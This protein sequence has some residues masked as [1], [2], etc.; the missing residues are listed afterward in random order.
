VDKYFYTCWSCD[1]T[2]KVIYTLNSLRK[3]K[4]LF[5]YDDGNK[6]INKDDI[7]NIVKNAVFILIF[8]DDK[9]LDYENIFNCLES[10]N[11]YNKDLIVVTLEGNINI[12][13]NYKYLLNYEDCF[14][15]Y[16]EFTKID[17]FKIVKYAEVLTF[18][19]YLAGKTNE[20]EKIYKNDFYEIDDN[21][22]A[23]LYFKGLDYYIDRN[24]NEALVYLNKAKDLNNGQAINLLSWCYTY[25][26]FDITDYDKA[27]ELRKIAKDLGSSDAAMEYAK[28]LAWGYSSNSK[29]DEALKLYMNLAMNGKIEAYNIIGQSYEYGKFTVID[30][31]EAYKWYKR[32]AHFNSKDA[33]FSLAKC[34]LH[35]IGIEED[36]D[37]GMKWLKKSA[38]S[39]HVKACLYLAN[40]Y[41]IY[42]KSS[43]EE[44]FLAFH[45]CLMAALNG[46][47]E[48]EYQLSNFYSSGIG[49]EKDELEARKWM[50]AAACDGHDWARTLTDYPGGTEEMI[51][52]RYEEYVFLKK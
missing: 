13:Y 48:A 22:S 50:W 3:N 28:N 39:G 23:E 2:K 52:K 12:R 35:G 7:D 16:N 45:Y 15:L 20:V 47:E 5:Y 11:K 38:N 17:L 46:D 27:H 18:K 8:I 51:N 9:Y 19:D 14:S 42:N 21:N 37:E 36:Y 10:A 33:M 49:V 43:K 6:R 29:Y 1:N 31:H 26:Y 32:G 25:S 24:L 41:Y 4:Y 30:Y 34:Y 40:R 44:E